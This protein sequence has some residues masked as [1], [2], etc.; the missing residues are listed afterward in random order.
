MLA[1]KDTLN[2]IPQNS[3][4]EINASSTVYISHDVLDLITEFKE[5]KAKDLNLKV[6]LSG[7]KDG[8]DIE[9]LKDIKTQ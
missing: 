1:I 6:K 9:N 5:I 2:K 3:K 4:V 8:Y 7:F